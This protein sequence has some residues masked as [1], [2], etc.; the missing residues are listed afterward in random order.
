MAIL[1]KAQA[2][3]IGLLVIV[4]L[5]VFI[6]LFVIRLAYLTQQDNSSIKDSI[7]VNN[8]VT[9]LTKVTICEKQQLAS[10]LK[11][12]Y[13]HQ[14]SCQQDSCQLLDE[15]LSLMMQLSG[16]SQK[17]YKLIAATGQENLL[18][19]GSCDI[20]KANAITSS[21][22]NIYLDRNSATLKIYICR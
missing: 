12:C 16:F 20:T 14:D 2:E 15:K 18:E 21:P 7:T 17:E 19:I 11:N 1:K 10:V 6:A 22:Y 13:N 4:T 9:A 5:I 8:M 3:T